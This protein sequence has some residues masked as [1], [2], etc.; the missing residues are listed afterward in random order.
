MKLIWLIIGYFFW[1]LGWIIQ[2]IGD[3]CN[4]WLDWIEEWLDYCED[5]INKDDR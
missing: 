1:T 5:H 4:S 2:L 3:W